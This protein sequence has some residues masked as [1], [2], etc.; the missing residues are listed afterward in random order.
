MGQGAR[1][2]WRRLD[3]INIYQ[4]WV[5]PVTETLQTWGGRL[6]RPD[7]MAGRQLFWLISRGFHDPSARFHRIIYTASVGVTD[8]CKKVSITNNPTQ[9]MSGVTVE[10]PVHS[11]WDWTVSDNSYS[12]DHGTGCV[13]S[14]RGI[15]QSYSLRSEGAN[16]SISWCTEY[17]WPCMWPC[18]LPTKATPTPR[19]SHFQIYNPQAHSKMADQNEASVRAKLYAK[20]YYL[21]RE[22]LDEKT[23]QQ[24]KNMIK[25]T[26]C[27]ICDKS[28][29]AKFGKRVHMREVH[30]IIIPQPNQH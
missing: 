19:P 21:P 23:I 13:S 25:N 27:D 1:G 28:F 9:G 16:M 10:E 24:L 3:L 4:L 11:E 15:T 5:Q 14:V 30:Q 22:L 7:H 2:C 26:T 8:I 17:K 29:R 18:S 6:R 12:L 20:L